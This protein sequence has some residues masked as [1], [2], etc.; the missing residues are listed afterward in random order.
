[1]DYKGKEGRPEIPEFGIIVKTAPF[2]DRQIWYGLGPQENYIDRN[3]GCK[4]GIYEA[5]VK[6]SLTPYVVPQECSKSYGNT[7]HYNCR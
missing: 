1:M 5:D 3:N 2:L 7:P 4:L 6:N